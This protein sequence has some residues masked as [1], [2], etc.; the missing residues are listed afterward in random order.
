MAKW[1]VIIICSMVLCR[2][3]SADA[4][5]A[6]SPVQSINE[7][8]VPDIAGTVKALRQ[9]K[10][11]GDDTT[12][13]VEIRP[14][15]TKLKHQLRDLITLTLN[16]PVS[17]SESLED[18]KKTLVAE[19]EKQGITP[20]KPDMVE[21][22]PDK[23]DPSYT[24]GDIQQVAVRRVDG[25]PDLIAATTRI[26]VCCGSDTSL[27]IYQKTQ[28]AWKLLMAQEA[29]GYKE[30]NGA[31]GSFGY[32]VSPSSTADPFFVVTKNVN[33]WC[34]SNWQSIR[35]HVLRPGTV[36]Y[37]PKVLLDRTET[38]YLGSFSE[39]T[40]DIQPTDFTIRFEGGQ[41]LDS[42]VLVRTHVVSYQ[43][44]GNEVRR[45]PPFAKEPAGFVDEWFHLPWEE[46]SKWVAPSMS[47][48][49]HALHERWR[50]ESTFSTEFTYYPSACRI[51]SGQWQVGIEFEPDEG[52]RLPAGIPKK[53]FLNIVE[54]KS[55]YFF[56]GISRSS[57][58]RCRF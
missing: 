49:L 31:Q 33:P 35:Y 43:V 58:P 32:A 26:G 48:T 30:V 13:P 42:G 51:K 57:H 12:V 11:S 23:I 14:L 16:S 46:A 52:K 44:Q 50:T 20:D 56:N 53:I 2:F 17:K 37:E 7:Q 18:V 8:A 41:T 28:G 38:I 22:W 45:V 6:G 10:L 47:S 29:T 1:L 34:T 3:G 19:F 40:I 55:G 25:R 27:Y 36:P 15:L 24:Y 9:V 21:V 4:A 39:G 5:E 54:K